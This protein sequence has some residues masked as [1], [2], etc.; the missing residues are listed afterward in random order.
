MNELDYLLTA[1]IVLSA[2]WAMFR[3]FFRELVALTGW[4]F[5]ILLTSEFSGKLEAY[6]MPWLKSSRAAGYVASVAIFVVVLLVFAILGRVIKGWIAS[7]GFSLGDRLAGLAFGLVRGGLIL[8]V[9]IAVHI[10]MD[11][12]ASRWSGNSVI[13]GY[14]KEGILTSSSHLPENSSLVAKMR[15]MGL[16]SAK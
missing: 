4:V 10:A 13:Y 1:V 15:R 8:I 11:E 12:P 6:L 2:L 5:A 16:N 9:A 14:G 3:G 7:K